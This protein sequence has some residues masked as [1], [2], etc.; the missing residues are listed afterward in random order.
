M[1]EDTSPH[2]GG[3]KLLRP[4]MKLDQCP[5]CAVVHEPSMPHNQQSLFWQYNFREKM[6]RWP[7]WNDAMAHCEPEMRKKWIEALAEHGITVKEE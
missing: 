1:N 5:E 3:F 4:E 7:T 6:G 2:L